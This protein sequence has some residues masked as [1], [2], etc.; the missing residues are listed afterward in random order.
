[1]DRIALVF[2]QMFSFLRQFLLAIASGMRIG[3]IAMLAWVIKGFSYRLIGNFQ[4]Y[5][6]QDLEDLE[7]N[8]EVKRLTTLGRVFRYTAS[9]VVSFVA[10]TL[11]LGELEVSVAPILGPLLWWGC[12]HGLSRRYRCW[13][14]GNAR[15][16]RNHA[17]RCSFLAEVN[18]YG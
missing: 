12:G 3:L 9:V 4:V 13:D 5:I 17:D 11:I 2:D 8:E 15:R 7:D 18:G 1:M 14:T 6:S 16:R 10:G